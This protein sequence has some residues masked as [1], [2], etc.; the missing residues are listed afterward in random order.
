MRVLVATIVHHPDDARISRRQIPALLAAGHT[1]TYLAPWSATSADVPHGVTALDVPQ[2]HGRR[3]L[4]AIRTA[5]GLIR[6]QAATADLVLL[7]DLELVLAVAG[8]RGRPPTVW[9][10]HEDT[11]AAVVDKAWLGGPLRPVARLGVRLF[12]RAAERRLHLLLAEDGYAARFRHAHPVVPNAP[13]VPATVP[14]SGSDRIVYLGRL[15]HLRGAHDLVALASRLPDGVRLELIGQA[16]TRVRPMLL[17]AHDAGLVV[18]HRFVPNDRALGMIQGA[19]AGVSLLHDAPNYRHSLPTKVLEYLANGLPVVTTPNPLAAR[20]VTEADAGF[21]IPYGHVDLAAE[22][23]R[24]LLADD[25]ARQRMADRGRAHVRAHLDWN[26][27]GPEFVSHL[28]SFAGAAP[29]SAPT[30]N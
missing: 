6:E 19:A 2:A 16:D 23:V 22:A 13:A 28:E 21:E 20:I 9:D 27:L 24:R 30:R 26:T 15:S 12:E 8:M 18:W 11:A 29:P 10:V 7:H 25:A 1:V 3:R 5:R 17:E 14:P 4:R